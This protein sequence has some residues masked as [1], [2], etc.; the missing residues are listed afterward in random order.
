MGGGFVELGVVTEPSY[1]Y[2]AVCNSCYDGDTITVDV[3]LG[4]GVW[5]HGQKL[6][7]FGIDAPE[8]RGDE[9]CRGLDSRDAL[10][11]LIEGR[12]VLVKTRRDKKGK[13]GRWLATVF[14]RSEEHGMMDVNRWLVS[15]GYAEK[16]EY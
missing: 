16:R 10:R 13:Y 2:R 1:V 5:V 4:L 6:R 14:F 8:V 7:L 15:L 12:E 3:D 11:D 9:R